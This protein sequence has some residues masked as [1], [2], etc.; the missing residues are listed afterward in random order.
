[1]QS[2]TRMHSG[3]VGVL[4]GFEDYGVRWRSGVLGFRV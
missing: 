1:M 2:V 3:G 4:L